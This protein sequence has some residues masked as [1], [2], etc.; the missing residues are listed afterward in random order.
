MTAT[1]IIRDKMKDG[2]WHTLASLAKLA[3]APPQS[4]S[5]RLRDLRKPEF[6]GLTVERR[7]AH[8][9]RRIEYRVVVQGSLDFREPRRHRCQFCGGK[10]YRTGGR[11]NIVKFKGEKSHG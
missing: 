1:S 9:G 3:D 10:G 6:G 11:V 4:V 8:G 5:A 2:K 7:V